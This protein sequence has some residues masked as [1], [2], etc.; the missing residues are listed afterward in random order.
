M[1]PVLDVETTTPDACGSAPGVNSSQEINPQC[2]SMS[3]G[4][5]TTTAF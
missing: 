3:D 5:L 4:R 1:I 2:D